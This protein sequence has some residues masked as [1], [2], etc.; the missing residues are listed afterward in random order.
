MLLEHVKSFVA[1]TR[2][3][4]LIAGCF[5]HQLK[6]PPHAFF[7]VDDQEGGGVHGVATAEVGPRLGEDVSRSLPLSAKEKQ[8]GAYRE[9]RLDD[10]AGVPFPAGAASLASAQETLRWSPACLARRTGLCLNVAAK[11][12]SFMS[13]KLRNDGEVVS[14]VGW[15]PG[16][17]VGSA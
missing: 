14:G 5:E 10:E 8:R 15:K 9:S 2:Q 17:L 13:I 7:I 4:E 11:V 16:S 1:G 3:Q 12:A 6:E